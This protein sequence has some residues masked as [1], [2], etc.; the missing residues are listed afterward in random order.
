MFNVAPLPG[1]SFLLVTVLTVLGALLS[2]GLPNMLVT[3]KIGKDADD[4][5]A[6][7][8]GRYVRKRVTE[9]IVSRVGTSPA[10]P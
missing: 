2:L 8:S 1:A 5:D 4:M 3:R 7:V 10:Q 9:A 6:D